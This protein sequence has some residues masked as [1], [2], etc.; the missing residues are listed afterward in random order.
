MKVILIDNEPLELS[1]LEKQL[2]EVGKFTVLETYYSVSKAIKA[3]D[4]DPPDLIFLD[5]EIGGRNG[6]DL[7]EQVQLK[8][9]HIKIVFV[10]AF[11]E[12]AVKAFELNAVDYIMKPVTPDRLRKTI[13]RVMKVKKQA[14]STKQSLIKCM[15]TFELISDGVPLNVQWRTTKAKELFLFLLH[16]QGSLVKK[17]LIIE[18]L[19]PDFEIKKAYTQLY[20]TI[21]LIRKALSV[22][23]SLTIKSIE[24]H[25]QLLLGEVKVDTIEWEKTVKHLP[26]LTSKTLKDF[27]FVLD[28]YKGDYLSREGYL[29]AEN[30][31]E[32]LKNFWY[33]TATKVG[34]FLFSIKNYE[35]SIT[36]FLRIQTMYPYIEESY[37]MLMK[38]YDQLKDS[39]NVEYQYR[40]LKNMLLE[41]VQVYPSHV[42]TEWYKQRKKKLA[43]NNGSVSS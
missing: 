43:I 5:V 17:D 2:M 35:D 41:E 23:P 32:R 26:Y 34:R 8:H 31:R 7:T 21:Y 6:L 10:T 20:S 25:Y 16:Y 11:K 15:P 37:F 9:P 30:E 40:L 19:W 3:I 24:D 38:L 18:V 1:Y 27:Q 14:S 42:V 22:F 33:M 12:H 4:R 29:W 13:N 28:G 36:L 39:Y